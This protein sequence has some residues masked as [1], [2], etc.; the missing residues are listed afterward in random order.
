MYYQ[1]ARNT[2]EAFTIAAFMILMLAMIANSPAEQR[3]VLNLKE[4]RKFVFP[5]CCIRYRP[6]K[7]Y[8]YFTVKWSVMQVSFSLEQSTF[9][10]QTWRLSFPLKFVIV[11]PLISIASVV[12]EVLGVFCGGS[13]SPYF[14]NIYL[15]AIDFF[16]VSIALYGLITL[17]TLTHEEL[18]GRR[19]LA[20]FMTI[21][22]VRSFVFFF[23]NWDCSFWLTIL[24][25]SQI[26]ALVFYQ[27]FVFTI[28]QRY[29]VIK[30]TQYWL[31]S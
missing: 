4:K 20:K 31:V 3:E 23:W 27:G 25:L 6:S 10:I 15:E 19:P 11:K 28:L 7:P 26:V 30:A 14:A 9:S 21:K 18:K 16:S 13:Q 29:N 8:F 22:I 12:T 1:L 2:Y 24:F 17:Y 5:C